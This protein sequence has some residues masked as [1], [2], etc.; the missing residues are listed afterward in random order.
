MRPVVSIPLLMFPDNILPFYVERLHGGSRQALRRCELDHAVE[1]FL[2]ASSFEGER[3]REIG[4]TR[5]SGGVFGDAGAVQRSK[6]DLLAQSLHE[7]EETDPSH[8][9]QD[10]EMAN[11]KD[12]RSLHPLD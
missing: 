1:F 4:L 6:D 5:A 9:H 7:I 12:L 11:G 10:R 8:Q 3:S 2:N